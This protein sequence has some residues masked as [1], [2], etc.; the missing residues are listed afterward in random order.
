MVEYN[1]Y[2]ELQAE[3][4]SSTDIEFTAGDVRAYRLRFKFF[5]DKVPYNV[6][7]CSLVIKAKRCD[8]II[9]VDQGVI[10]SDGDAF[11][12]VKS[13][14]YAVPG[15][16]SLEVILV[17]ENGSYLTAKELITRVRKGYGEGNLK[18]TNTIPVL[19][20][21]MAQGAKAEQAAVT[22]QK[23]VN[24]G[25][26]AMTLDSG[27]EAT[28]EKVDDGERIVLRLGIP[29][30]LPGYTPVKARTILRR[31]RRRRWCKRYWRHCLTEMR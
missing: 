5:S 19:T 31:Q 12:D 11:Y 7:G 6:S 4:S 9:I 24:M 2:I 28:V 8:K 17:A 3:R 15:K 22:A 21:L 18:A 1:T 14:I 23:M 10:T 16:L 13:S 26:S 30:G 27:S 25:V 20:S 29:Q